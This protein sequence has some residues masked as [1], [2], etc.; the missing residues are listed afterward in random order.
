MKI[1]NQLMPCTLGKSR[2]ILIWVCAIAVSALA[3]TA[4]A[5]QEPIKPLTII[6]HDAD[7]AELGRRLFSDVRLSGNNSTSCATCHRLDQYGVDNQAKSIGATGNV[8]ARN[9]PT[10]FNSG[11]YFTQMWDGRIPDLETRVQKAV[12]SPTLMGMPSW[13]VAVEKIAAVDLYRDRFQALYGEPVSANNIQHA[14]AEFQ[15]S[16]VLVNSPFDR[17]LQGDENAISEKAKKG[18]R[19]F[20]EYGCS[21][22]HQGANVGGNLFQKMGALKPIDLKKWNNTDV[23]RYKITGKEWDKYVFKVPSLRLAV[24]TAPYFHDG[25]AKTLEDAIKK[26]INYQLDRPVPQKHIDTIVEFL[27]TLPGELP[28]AVA[29]PTTALTTSTTLTSVKGVKP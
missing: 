1:I 20:K 7:K 22:C 15:R 6:E 27:K 9:T 14:I 4:Y 3:H 13:D 19:W 29:P 23:G 12:V 24:H 17:F 8:L 25:S 2:L 11:G 18:Y 21:S 5:Q 16:L 10:V 28:A 26:M